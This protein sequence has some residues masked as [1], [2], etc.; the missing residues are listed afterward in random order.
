V[1][2]EEID[3][4]VGELKALLKTDLGTPCEVYQRIVG[5]H[6]DVRQWNKGQKE[7][8]K[9]RKVFELKGGTSDD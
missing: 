6:R 7:I 8:Y 1:T 2:I 5:Y 9:D 4:Q 3:K